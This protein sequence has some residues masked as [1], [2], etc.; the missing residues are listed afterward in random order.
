M[1]RFEDKVAAITGAGSGIGA[2]LA[3]ELAGRRCHL[4]LCDVNE[5]GL[6]ATAT[7][8]R[9]SGVQVT[10]RRVDVADRTQ[11]H[12]WADATALAHG[13]VNLVFNNAGV[14]VAGTVEDTPYRDIEWI[15]NINFWGV[16]HGTKAFLPHLVASGDG[17]VINISSVFGLVGAPSQSAYNATKFA[18]RGYTEALRGELRMLETC[19]GATSVHPGGIQTRIARNGRIDASLARF[20]LDPATAG[21][22][23]E[24]NFR[25]TAGQAAR[26]IL[27][28]VARNKARVLIGPEAYLIDWIARLLPAHYHALTIRFMKRGR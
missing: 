8:A 17:H 4:A 11:V 10:T 25:T 24:R 9:R 20:G 27:A 1:K 3:L 7:Q 14:S 13:R 21:T 6:E 19:V 23:F 18:V 5:A 26:V 22:D 16:V 2:A 28:G 12:A 15:V